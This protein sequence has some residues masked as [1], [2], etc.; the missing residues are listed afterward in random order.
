MNQKT[1]GLTLRAFIFALAL[2]LAVGPGLPLLDGVAYAQ[3]A[4]P[5]LSGSVNPDG[6]AELTWAEDGAADSY[7]VYRQE[8][9]TTTWTSLSSTTAGYT[10]S[11]VTAGKSY[12]YYVRAVENGTKG[13]WSNGV[14]LTI[15]GGTAAPTGKPT[16]SAAPTANSV[17]AGD[18]SWTT[19]S[20]AA[21]Y[22]LRRWDG[23]AWAR[24]GGDLTGTTYNDTGLTAGSTYYYIIRAV[25]TGGNGPWSDQATLVMP[26]GPTGK[27]T[28]SAAQ[29]ANSFTAVDLSWTAVSDATHY[30]LRRWDSAAG[31]WTPIGGDLT[32]TTYND[33]GLTAGST[34]YY[35]IR[36]VNAGGSGPWSSDDGVGF[37][38]VALTATTTVPVLTLTHTSR[39]V[40]DLSWTPVASVGATYQVQRKATHTQD[41]VAVTSPVPA[42]VDLA[43]AS[44][45]TTTSVTDSNA[46]PTALDA[47][48]DTNITNDYTEFEYRVR[49]V[50]NG[51]GGDWSNV[52]KVKVLTTGTRPVA[53]ASLTASA[54]SSSSIVLGWTASAG[55]DRY[56]IRHKVGEGSYSTS[57]ITVSGGTSDSHTHRGLSA[58]TKYTYQVRAVNI[59]GPSDWS[60]EKSAT[61]PAASGDT[62]QLGTPSGLT[63]VDDTKDTE[64]TP[65]VK[66]SW[67]AVSGANSYD[68]VKWSGSSWDALTLTDDDITARSHR[69]TDSNNTAGTT[70]YYAVRAKNTNDTTGDTDDDLGEWSAPVN[71]TTKPTKPALPQDY[72]IPLLTVTSASSIWITWAAI[73]D[74]A[75]Y[76][77]EW[78]HDRSNA[79]WNRITVDGTSYEHRNRSA[80]TTYYYRVRGKNA[81]GM[82]AYSGEAKA[83]TWSG[84][85]AT[86]TGLTAADATSGVTPAIKLTW[87]TVTGATGYELQQWTTDTDPDSWADLGGTAGVTAVTGGSTKTVN[88]TAGVSQ[89][90]TYYYIIRAV[91]GDVKSDWS[92]SVTGMAKYTAP[93]AP[94][95][96]TANLTPIGETVVRITWP[97]VANAISYELEWIEGNLT[98]FTDLTSQTSITLQTSP[99]YYLH[100]NLN[101]GK[102]Y[103]YRIRAVLPQDVTSAWSAVAQTYT[104]PLRPQ[105]TATA[106]ISTSIDLKWDPVKVDSPA[107]VSG[108]LLTGDSYHVQRRAS[109][110]TTWTDLE[111]TIADCTA[112][113]KCKVTDANLEA[114]TQ[115]RYRIR[116]RRDTTQPAITGHTS[117]WDYEQQRTPAN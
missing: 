21:H 48:P 52:K 51:Q 23:T 99:R 27:P 6:H 19:V 108:D 75:S 55:A 67:N 36:A 79:A 53:P 66:V 95:F 38:T 56:E 4:A 42:F 40:V 33:T 30:D 70:Y 94:T 31:S 44:S 22:E 41:G 96:A 60:T 11:G 101:A 76:D 88:D 69:D 37:T 64:T 90:G 16:L 87:N 117:Y 100:R 85:L 92:A 97:A 77:L 57:F 91:S 84:R 58:Q 115:Y 93:S 24:I 59:N 46:T 114:G 83:T 12:T 45:L 49:A 18:L 71:V 65:V 26:G 43:G 20:G 86:P 54:V 8:V 106:Q 28:L 110:A 7:D 112:A 34:Y 61:T 17:T 78:R 105:L 98:V 107:G 63:A 10:D 39:T 35:I 111:E 89:G 113:D 5:T 25:N 13:S 1:V 72:A 14:T 47:N 116:V 74:A 9:G 50:V 82:T 102:K 3:L 32:G 29:T 104:R 81:S 2:I 109:G 80:S 68:L 103:S 15:P 73:T 62:G